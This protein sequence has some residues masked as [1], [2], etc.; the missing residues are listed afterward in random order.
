MKND[1]RLASDTCDLRDRLDCAQ[2]VVGVHH[3]N[4]RC[5]RP[6]RAADLVRI[7]DPATAH[8]YISYLAALALDLRAGAEHGWM[9]HHGGDHMLALA[10]PHGAQQG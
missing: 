9:L 7:H 2:L 8:G 4:Q 5:I 10:G 1:T 3:R 6:Q